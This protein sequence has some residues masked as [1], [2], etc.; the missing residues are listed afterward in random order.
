MHATATK[1]FDA[2]KIPILTSS[3]SGFSTVVKNLKGENNFTL[4]IYILREIIFMRNEPPF[5]LSS[6]ARERHDP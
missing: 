6:E 2:L 4:D 3:Y 5:L 1:R